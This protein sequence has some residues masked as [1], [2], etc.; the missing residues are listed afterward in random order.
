MEQREVHYSGSVQGVGFR[1]TVR[2]LASG[3][4]VTGFVRNLP[5]GSVQLVVEGEPAEI[6]LFLKSI[7]AEMGHYVSRV[8]EQARPASRHFGGFEIRF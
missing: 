3:M 7:M 4:A 1:Y 5:D 6:K 8:D 2:S